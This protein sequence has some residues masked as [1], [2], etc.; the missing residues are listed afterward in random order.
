MNLSGILASAFIQ[1]VRQGLIAQANLELILLPSPE[2]GIAAMHRH[3]RLFVFIFE[4]CGQ[5]D[6]SDL[7]FSYA[8][9]HDHSYIGI[10]GKYH[11]VSAFCL[12]VCLSVSHL[13][14]SP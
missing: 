14:V 7:Y 11:S 3:A 4:M 1:L 13:S 8:W 12:S 10:S 5:N 6:T 9:P 2:A